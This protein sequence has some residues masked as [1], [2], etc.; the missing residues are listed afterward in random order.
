MTLPDERYRALQKAKQFLLELCN[1]S[2]TKRVPSEIRNRARDVLRHF[3]FDYH[4]EE[5]RHKIPEDYGTWD[6]KKPSK[7]DA[8]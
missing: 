2:K 7:S 6:G 8:E 1:P 5:L 3:P 4:L